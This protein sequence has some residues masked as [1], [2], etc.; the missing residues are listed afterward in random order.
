MKYTYG[1]PIVYDIRKTFYRLI[2]Q[3]LVF[4]LFFQ[5]DN[6]YHVS[7]SEPFSYVY[8]LINRVFVPLKE[9]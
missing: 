1:V 2:H 9:P 4:C 3:S 6:S 7:C 8:L 5:R